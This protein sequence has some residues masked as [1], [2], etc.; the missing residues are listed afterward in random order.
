M[1]TKKNFLWV[2]WS[3]VVYCAALVGIIVG[4][5][6]LMFKNLV[7]QYEHLLYNKAQNFKLFFF[8]FPVIGLMIIHFLRMYVFNKKKNK[9]ISEVLEAVRNDK[10][11][12][13]YKV[14]SHFFNGFLT[15]VFGGSTGIEVSTVVATS[16]LGDMASRKDPIFKKYR[17]EFIGS[18]IACGVTLL[19]CSPLAGLFFSYETI[20][21]QRTK[22]FW[23]THLV[24]VSF[25][26]LILLLMNV[27][28]VFNLGNHDT[29]IHYQV[30]PFFVILSLLAALYG[31]YMTKMVTWIKSKNFLDFNPYLQILIGG[32]LLGGL[33]F[34]LPQLYGDGYHAIE[35]IIHNNRFVSVGFWFLLGALFLKPFATGF[36]LKLGG[37]GGVFAPSIFGGAIM[38]ALIG[39]IVQTYFFSD[40][41][42]INFVILGVGLTVA[43]T[44]HA[45]F[46]ALFLTF[47]MF[48]SYGLWIPLIIL[49]FLS[50]FISKRIF[51]YTVYT[52]ALKK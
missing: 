14:P 44:L 31:V 27:N 18:A 12:P 24:S 9:G 4:L 10:K 35:N 29:V 50:F 28:P 38:G 8:I 7:E 51:P 36:S 48:N 41:Q 22:V 15:V 23:I 21:K 33:L 11:L 17:K 46:T 5:I 45:P 6:T 26:T 39:F 32:L 20:G 25:A 30:I 37:D 16:A 34:V 42:I 43:A 1:V 19:F 49:V 13:A 2:K 47:G 52:L 3:R 40:A